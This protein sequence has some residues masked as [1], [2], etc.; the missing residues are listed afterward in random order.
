LLVTIASCVKNDPPKREAPKPEP[1]PTPAA[2]AL[3][4]RVEDEDPV[5][6]VKKLEA[7]VQS[8]DLSGMYTPG[9]Y[10]LVTV[11]LAR[12]G[13]VEVEHLPPALHKHGE[14]IHS[15]WL[16]PD[17]AIFAAGYMI[18]GVPGP[19]T[20]AIWHKKKDA[21]IK[22]TYERAEKELAVVWGRASDD[23]YAVGKDTFLHWSGTA[24]TP[25][26]REGVL[27]T[28]LGLWGNASD[29]YLVANDATDGSVY[30]RKK[31]GAWKKETT[32]RSCFLRTIHGAGSAVWAA[33]D[34]GVILR[35][36][37]DGTWKE[38]RRQP[39]GLVMSLWAL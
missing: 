21:P 15:M 27:G 8:G 26:S 35:R 20:G 4:P 29:L 2:S 39:N 7:K 10:D 19:D 37:G 12:D 14:S 33:G 16:A 3:P 38:E 36:N 31:D 23:V 22:R 34:C 5:E 17:G 11:P 24:W 18:T 32:V 9:G 13:K 1:T 28:V 6:T 30:S 25:D